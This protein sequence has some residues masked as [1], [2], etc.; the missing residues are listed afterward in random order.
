[1]SAAHHYLSLMLTTNP[2]AMIP[3]STW[4]ALCVLWAATHPRAFHGNTP[5]TNTA[6]VTGML[7]SLIPFAAGFLALWWITE[8]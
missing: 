3:A 1:M 2:W 5:T 4:A 7:A 8:L 6:L